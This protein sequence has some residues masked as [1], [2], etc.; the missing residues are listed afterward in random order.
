MRFHTLKITSVIAVGWLLSSCSGSTPASPSDQA[1][2]QLELAAGALP[3]VDLQLRSGA[4]LLPDGAIRLTL[5][6]RCPQ[7]FS[8]IEGPV[9][10]MQGPEFQEVHG[11][12][13]FTT[14]CDGRWHL[15]TVR[16]IAPEGG[17]QR[18]R[19]KASASLM[20]E[21]PATGEFGQGDDNRVL[22]IR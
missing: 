1:V 18:G 20:V 8:V 6:A 15:Q 3:R 2:N 22:K 7:G 21:V 11:E 19:A 14:T 17:Y 16:V 5:R 9:T 13:F 12:G 4:T 10:V